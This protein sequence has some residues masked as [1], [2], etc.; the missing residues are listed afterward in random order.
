MALGAIFGWGALSWI[1]R[2]NGWAPGPIGD[3]ETG[4]QGWIQ[5]PGLAA[6]L[7]DCVVKLSWMKPKALGDDT[8]ANVIIEAQGLVP[9]TIPSWM[10]NFCL[11]LSIVFCT[12]LVRFSIGSF[13]AWPEILFAIALALP[14]SLL[15]IQT[16]G[17]TGVNMVS[18]LGISFGT[19][20]GVI[21]ALTLH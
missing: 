15:G 4:V 10:I 13:M 12:A 9:S 11:A 3:W 19:S 21:R 1:S 16:Y 14:L 17:Q 18:A 5:W 2:A 7:A 8:E 6:L 20:F